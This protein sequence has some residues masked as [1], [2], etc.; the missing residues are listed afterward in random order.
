MGPDGP[1]LMQR[2]DLSTL[3]AIPWLPGYARIACE[4]YVG[5]EPYPYDSRGVLTRVTAAVKAEF[6]YD[7]YTGLEPEFYLLKTCPTTGRPIPAADGDALEKPCYDYA[8]LSQVASY[9][10]TLVAQV[11]ACGMDVYQIDHEDANG[12]YEVN[13]TYD[14]AVTAADHY[15]LFKM[16]AS[17]LAKERGLMV[18]F[19]PKPFADKTGNGMHVHLS[20]GQGEEKNLFAGTDDSRGLGLSPLAYQFLAG[21]LRHAPALAAIACPTINSY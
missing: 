19:M 16:A 20:L 7:F 4:G 8:A 21:V 15:T 12:Q 10:Q 9:L 14:L 1:D 13:F 6:G 11:R 18:S 3:R 17:T 2:G 5:G